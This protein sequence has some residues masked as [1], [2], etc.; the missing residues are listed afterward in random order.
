MLFSA[1]GDSGPPP[2]TPASVLRKEGPGLTASEPGAVLLLSNVPGTNAGCLIAPDADGHVDASHVTMLPPRA[3]EACTALVSIT[4]PNLFSEPK[5]YISYDTFQGCSSLTSITLPSNIRNLGRD[6]FQGCT[7]LKSITIPS[8]LRYTDA[9]VFKDC[10]SL[11]SITLFSSG[12]F[13][14]FGESTFEGCSQSRFLPAP[15]A[16]A[17]IRSKAAPPCSRS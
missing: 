9:R 15:T 16:S 1:L 11:Q 2:S 5:N 14:L 3:F 8:D 12:S 13:D 4:L 6:A 17:A 7:S 10:T